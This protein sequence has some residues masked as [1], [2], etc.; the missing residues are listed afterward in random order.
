MPWG[1]F[2]ALLIDGKTRQAQIL[3]ILA[4]VPIS[5]GIIHDNALHLPDVTHPPVW[6]YVIVAAIP[7]L[8]ARNPSVNEPVPS[9][10]VPSFRPPPAPRTPMA[11]PASCNVPVTRGPG[12]LAESAGGGDRR[13]RCPY[14]RLS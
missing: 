7:W 13:G 1:S 9:A 8:A 6:G 2:T 14:T 10:P 5:F 3:A 11:G 12:A 4:A